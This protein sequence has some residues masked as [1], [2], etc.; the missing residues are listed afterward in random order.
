MRSRPPGR[1][2]FRARRRRSRGRS[3]RRRRS[4]AVSSRRG[5][6]SE[7][8]RTTSAARRRAACSASP[9]APCRCGSSATRSRLSS[10]P[11]TKRPRG[12][13]AA[14]RYGPSRRREP[15]SCTTH[16]RA[17]RL[18]EQPARRGQPHELPLRV[19]NAGDL[20]APD[21]VADRVHDG[22]PRR[23]HRRRDDRDDRG[24]ERERAQVA[25][26]PRDGL[27]LEV[28]GAHDLPRAP[29]RV[30]LARDLDSLQLA[31]HSSRSFSLSR[32]RRR[33]ELTVPRGRS[34]R[35][36][37]SPGVYSRR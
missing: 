34:S 11:A 15:S 14:S 7:S 25:A 1:R 28:R 19:A 27:P 12:D 8:P 20:L 6:R 5:R 35:S 21:G 16:A 30:V 26:R 9:S 22:A 32:P 36:A 24:G 17:R 23:C 2:D 3:S 10:T 33:R 4:R 31:L 13:Q 37:I 29:A 18:D